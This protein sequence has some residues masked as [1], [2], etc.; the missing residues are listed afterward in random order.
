MPLRLNVDTHSGLPIYLQLVE[1]I[2]RAIAV[3]ILQP[4]ELLPSVKTLAGALLV[5]PATIGRALRE[6]ERAGVIVSRVGRGSFVSPSGASA[7]AAC[8]ADETVARGFD[9]ALREARS[10][11]VGATAAKAIFQRYFDYWYPTQREQEAHDDEARH[12]TS[13][14]V[15]RKRTRA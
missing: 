1:Q 2:Q 9:A 11:G 6:L 13:R 8:A 15:V 14:Q 4:G 10:F 3:G 5:N 12:R 7:V